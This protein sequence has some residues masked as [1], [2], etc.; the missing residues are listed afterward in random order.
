[1]LWLLPSGATAARA[2]P[3]WENQRIKGEGAAQEEGGAAVGRRGSVVYQIISFG[4]I[5]RKDGSF[6]SL[7]RRLFVPVTQIT[8]VLDGWTVDEQQ[9]SYLLFQYVR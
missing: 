4:F 7:R 9:L 3:A 8:N 1:V 2:W 5:H 6:C